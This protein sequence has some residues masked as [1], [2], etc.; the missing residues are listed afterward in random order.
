MS[1]VG[2]HRKPLSLGSGEP[3]YLLQG[4][5]KGLNGADYNLL[6]CRKGV[7]QLDTLAAALASN[8]LHHATDALEIENSIAELRIDDVPVGDDNYRREQLFVVRIMQVREEVGG[9]RNRV[10]LA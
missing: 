6:A 4:E 3:P 8:C 9:P 10:S 5:R 1:F 2:D 7:R